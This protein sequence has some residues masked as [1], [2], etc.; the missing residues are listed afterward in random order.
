MAGLG[1]K[2]GVDVLS[3]QLTFNKAFSTIS[4]LRFTSSLWW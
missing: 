1:L 3:N 4:L 2:S